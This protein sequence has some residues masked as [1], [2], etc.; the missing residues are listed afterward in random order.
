[1]KI[2]LEN[3]RISAAVETLGAELVSYKRSD[4]TEMLW[5]GNAKYWSGHAP[6]LFPMVGT[7][8]N[9]KT[10]IDG[11]W[12]EMKR[13]GI[14]R[15]NEFAVIKKSANQVELL[16]HSNPETKKQYPF[17]FEFIVTYTLRGD[18]L[19]TKFTVI[20][21]GNTAMPFVVGGHPAFNVPMS[22]EEE[23][24]DYE[25]RF[26]SKESQKCPSIDLNSGMI[27]PDK[28]NYQIENQD[29][30]PLR[31]DLFYNDALVFE[32]LSSQS[33]TIYG[34]KSGRGLRMRIDE[35]PMLGIWSSINDGP[36]V[37]LEPWT[38]CATRTD[39][40]DEFENKHLMARLAPA[41][42]KSYSFSVE[43]F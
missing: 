38:G 14:A 17:D 29:V 4:K 35:F 6:V 43:S 20:N 30:I 16:L 3:G 25:I 42:K 21:T 22:D 13:H 33:V 19:E 40:D 9:N 41:E 18:E 24:E 10:I 39:E 11:K 26:S 7:L 37:A 32:N 31:H 15:R 27:N 5:Q 28:L 23:F 8:R 12:Y 36:Y 2:E 1:M 34:T